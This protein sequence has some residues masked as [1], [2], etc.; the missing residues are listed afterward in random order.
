[1]I[2]KYRL[3]WLLWIGLGV[4]AT[5]SLTWAQD[6]PDRWVYQS[7]ELLYQEG[8]IPHYPIEWV[9]SGNQ[10]SR[11]E[12]A[13]Y[14]KQFIFTHLE[15][16][17]Q[18]TKLTP[19]TIETLQKLVAEF[20]TELADLGI[21]ST[22]FYGISPNLV[23]SED[24]SNDGYQDL[25]SLLLKNKTGSS[26]QDLSKTQNPFYF[27]GQYYKELVQKFFLF[28]PTL[29]VRPDYISLLDGKLSSINI[30][31][32]PKLGLNPSFLV[33][34]GNLPVKSNKFISG[35]YLFPIEENKLNNQMPLL[36]GLNDSV[37][38][39]MEEVNKIQQIDS[40]WRFDG[41]LLLDGYRKLETDLQNKLLLG[42]LNDGLKIGSLL[43]YTEN[44]SN[45]SDF[46]LNNFGL[47][48]NN[49]HQGTVPS[50][51]DLDSLSGK[52]LQS[53]QINIQGSFTLTPRATVFGGFDFVYRNSDYG[54]ERFLPSDTKA[55]AGMQYHLNDYWTVLTYQSVVNSQSKDFLSTTSFGL[56]YNDW[57]SLWMAYQLLNFDDPVLTG[58]VA[59]KF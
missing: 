48:L 22:D 31:Y 21:K 44:P 54:V 41:P 34:K 43:V 3:V 12:Y 51:V 13:Y 57:A 25:D 11:F 20:R 37:L 28:I 55:S 10:L 1:M 26:D 42:N 15:R 47:P 36:S 29:A 35:Y 56:E 24:H 23:N 6:N 18:N 33:I 4:V 39:L 32:Q 5:V 16:E 38:V 52:Y 40:L 59:F 19:K 14:L 30:V 58:V 9:N 49:L 2:R 27:Y 46:N 8:W 45:K 50:L 7:M 17:N 53:L